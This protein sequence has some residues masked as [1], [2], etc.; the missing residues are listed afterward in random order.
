MPGFGGKKTFLWNFPAS[1]TLAVENHKEKIYQGLNREVKRDF[2]GQITLLHNL[3]L[4]LKNIREI[5][6]FRTHHFTM[7]TSKGD[8]LGGSDLR[9]SLSALNLLSLAYDQ[10]GY[11]LFPQTYPKSNC[12]YVEQLEPILCAVWILGFLFEDKGGFQGAT[13]SRCCHQ[14]SFRHMASSE[15]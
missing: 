8:P 5:F 3:L 4:K 2:C 10:R 6:P 14:V 9:Y 15:D 7:T 12:I 11:E 1:K 13:P